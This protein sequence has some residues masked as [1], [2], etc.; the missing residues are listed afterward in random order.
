MFKLRKGD[1]WKA[2]L[3]ILLIIAV[4]YFAYWRVAG[5]L[6]KPAFKP[7]ARS[8]PETAKA[9]APE[10][11]IQGEE[12]FT[13]RQR[14]TSG[15]LAKAHTS[16]DPFRPEV[17]ERSGSRTPAPSSGGSPAAGQSPAGYGFWLTGVVYG[18]RPLA[19]VRSGEQH[20][21]V[22]KGEYL[23]GEWRVASIS[24]QSV[25]LTKGDQRLTLDLSASPQ[26][27]SPYRR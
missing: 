15:E 1:V 4:G 24:R 18:D 6:G 2:V 16:P 21:F 14:T 17:S 12:M 10:K 5:T 11:I 19:V 9:Q 3:L 27:T 13:P 7:A 26:R 8:S 23:P 20:F 22:R 25:T